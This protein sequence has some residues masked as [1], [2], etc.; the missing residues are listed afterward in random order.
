MPTMVTGDELRQ[1][2]ERKT[3]IIDGAASCAEGI[4]Y[5][6]RLSAHILKAS[7]GGPIDAL[8]LSVAERAALAVEPGEMVFVLSEERLNLP[9]DMKAELSPKRKLSHAGILVLGGFCVDPGY[10]GPLLLGLYN[11][12]STRFQLLPGKKV[13]AATFYKLEDK[14]RGVFPIPLPL[15]DF[16]DELMQ[17]M[18]KYSPVALLSIAETVEKVRADLESLRNEFRSREDWYKRF[19]HSLEQHDKQ[20]EALIG[21]LNTEKDNRARGEDNLSQAIQNLEKTLS[22]LKGAAWA[23]LGLA[24]IIGALIAW[25]IDFFRAQ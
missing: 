19:E 14:E 7:F 2:V 15:E 5:D 8:K 22:W 16:P 21:G 18:Q 3:F 23:A 24:T 11:F 17:V 1:A 20:I 12:S 4:K 10:Q 13:I 25:L 9:M 6:F